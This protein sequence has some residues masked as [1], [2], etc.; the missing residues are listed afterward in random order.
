MSSGRLW[1]NF[2]AT[3]LTACLCQTTLHQKRGLVGGAYTPGQ[4]AIAFIDL[5][6]EGLEF[7]NIPKAKCMLDFLVFDPIGS[8]KAPLSVC[9]LPVES[10]FRGVHATHKG[11]WAMMEIVGKI[12]VESNGLIC[13]ISFDAHCTHAFI[14]QC[15]HGDFTD[16]DRESLKD[17]PFF[18][19]LKHRQMP[20]NKLPRL[21]I[22]V[23]LYRGEPFYAQ[24]GPRSLAGYTMR[25]SVC[26]EF[27]FLNGSFCRRYGFCAIPLLRPRNQKLKRPAM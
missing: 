18:S 12:L 11:C 1:A 8:D 2:D 24:P 22:A 5:D 9:S 6:C 7:E 25:R 10:A 19:E 15:I 23:C 16:I 27:F 17:V 13:G 20:P 4:E 26:V 21:P 3:Y 14:R